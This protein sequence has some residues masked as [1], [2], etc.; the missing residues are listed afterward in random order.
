MYI[1]A[2][3]VIFNQHDSD[4]LWILH[5]W[6]HTQWA[7]TEHFQAKIF[8][9]CCRMV[10][11]YEKENKRIILLLEI[12]RTKKGKVAKLMW[13]IDTKIEPL[14]THGEEEVANSTF[15]L[16]TLIGLIW[17]WRSEKKQ[18]T[19]HSTLDAHLKLRAAL[20]FPSIDSSS[21]ERKNNSNSHKRCDSFNFVI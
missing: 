9:M 13:N 3:S 21:T 18:Q 11:N 19:Q 12:Q 5:V 20:S 6:I 7:R 2:N 14:K 15:K 1:I 16:I 10:S 4:E 17:R 8:Q